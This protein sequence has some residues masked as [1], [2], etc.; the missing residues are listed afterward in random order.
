[1][2]SYNP[3]LNSYFSAEFPRYLKDPS[4]PI[5]LKEFVGII[6]ASKIWGES[7][8]GKRVQIFCDNDSVCDV[9]TNLKPKDVKMQAHLREFLYWVCKFNFVP[10]VSKIG[11]KENDIADFLSRN[12]SEDDATRFFQRENLTV[13]KKVEISDGLYEFI[14]DW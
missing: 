4:I 5:H 8:T 12:F 2:G 7:W 14:A 3:Q 6:I 10:V 1:M 13:P 9:V 11:T